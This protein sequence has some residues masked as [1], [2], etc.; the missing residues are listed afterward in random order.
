LLCREPGYACWPIH[1]IH[2]TLP[3]RNSQLIGFLR[4]HGDL[5]GCRLAGK[6]HNRTHANHVKYD[7]LAGVSLL[8]RVDGLAGTSGQSG[9][10]TQLHILWHRALLPLSA[11]VPSL[12]LLLRTSNTHISLSLHPSGVSAIIKRG[13]HRALLP[14]P[15]RY[16]DGQGQS[17]KKGEHHERV[18]GVCRL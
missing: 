17:A 11:V 9:R 14:F 7:A 10:S 8:R 13:I 16:V 4:R 3:I 5:P 12:F 6:R 2:E 15:N 18:R 1:C